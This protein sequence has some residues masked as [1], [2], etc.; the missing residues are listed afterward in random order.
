MSAVLDY[1]D[2][3]IEPAKITRQNCLEEAQKMQEFTSKVSSILKEHMFSLTPEQF[4]RMRT[5]VYEVKV[6]IYKN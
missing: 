6:E 4:E 3:Q 1:E 5:K 2:V